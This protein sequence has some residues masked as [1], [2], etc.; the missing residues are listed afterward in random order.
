MFKRLVTTALHFYVMPT[1][2]RSHARASARRASRQERERDIV[3]ATRSLFDERG[4]Q[5]A[6]IDDIARAVGINKALIYRHFSSKDELFVLTMTRYLEELDGRLREIPEDL[7][8]VEQFGTAGEAY[9]DFMLQYPAF[10]D[11]A[12][13]LMRRPF[14]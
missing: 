5:D 11:C 4:L 9:V 3:D 13:M 1:R 7:D 6:P 8:P 12:L 14:A 10:L 2:E